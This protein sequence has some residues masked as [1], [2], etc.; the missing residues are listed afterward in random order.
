MF[1]M[2]RTTVLEPINLVDKALNEK[3]KSLLTF[4][5]EKNYDDLTSLKTS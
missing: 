1:P 5:E 3:S 4:L 2:K